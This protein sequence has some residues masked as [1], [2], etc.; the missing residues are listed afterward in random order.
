MCWMMPGSWL[1]ASSMRNE[2]SSI[3]TASSAHASASGRSAPAAATIALR[4][5]RLGLMVSG[6]YSSGRGGGD[7][8]GAR[9][10]AI[11]RP[12]PLEPEFVGRTFDDFLFRPRRGVVRSRRAVRLTSHLTRSIELELPIVSANMDSVT[13]SDMARAIALEGGLGFI[14]RAMP[15]EAQAA[16]VPRVKRR[17]GYVVEEPIS[18]P[19]DATLAEAREVTRRHRITGILIEEG[20]GSGVLA[21]LLSNRDMP[22]NDEA[23]D[24]K[25]EDFMTPFDRLHVAPPDIGVREAERLLF[26]HRIEKLPLVDAERRIRGLITK[27]DLQ[28]AREQPDS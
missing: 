25:V 26:E 18:L 6:Y 4:V 5:M 23:L 1:Y 20:R 13:T 9:V 14:H 22:W 12:M 10:R 8:H 3:F 16:E 27:S 11:L 21:G 24:R 19:R 7:G 17:H 2:L 15:I 28:L